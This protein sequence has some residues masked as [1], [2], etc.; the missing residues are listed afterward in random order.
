[1]CVYIHIYLAVT[2]VAECVSE[3]VM[4]WQYVTGP[5]VVWVGNTD[6]VSHCDLTLLTLHA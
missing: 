1:M 5:D 2:V 3:S 6:A 4:Y